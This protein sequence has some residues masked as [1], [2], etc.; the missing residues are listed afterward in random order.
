MF[1]HQRP[2]LPYRNFGY[3][4]IQRINPRVDSIAILQVH[5]RVRGSL[6]EPR[7]QHERR[8][9]LY[10]VDTWILRSARTF[11]ENPTEQPRQQQSTDHQ[12][13]GEYAGEPY[14]GRA[15]DAEYWQAVD[16][17]PTSSTISRFLLVDV[18]SRFIPV[19]L[20]RGRSG[21]FD[22]RASRTSSLSAS[23]AQEPHP[24]RHRPARLHRRSLRRYARFVDLLTGLAD[25]SYGGRTTDGD[26]QGSRPRGTCCGE[27]R[28][29]VTSGR[30]GCRR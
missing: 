19:I 29:R 15:T 1:L 14:G 9:R 8:T 18:S 11:R 3:T 6:H 27:L 12:S 13:D 4:D 5:S 28:H 24:R 7:N 17:L 30:H 23:P 16:H 21:V 10:R 20:S 2:P 22:P 25:G 26:G